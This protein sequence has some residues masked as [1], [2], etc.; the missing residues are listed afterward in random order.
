M[1]LNESPTQAISPPEHYI[2]STERA[3][4]AVIAG[5]AYNVLDLTN[6]VIVELLLDGISVSLA[7]ADTYEPVL[8]ATGIGDGCHG[9]SFV[10]TPGMLIGGRVAQVVIANRR[11]VIAPPILLGDGPSRN[12]T[13]ALAPG[14]AEWLGGLHL[15]GWLRPG[16]DRERL[17]VRVRIDGEVV[18]LSH[19]DRWRHLAGSGVLRL[20]P[21]FSLH[22]PERF[23]DGHTKQ[24]HITDGRGI[25]LRGSPLHLV[26]LPDP[27]E[28]LAAGAYG[29]EAG[30]TAVRA[31]LFDTLLPASRTLA[32]MS[33]WLETYPNP[34]ADALECCLALIVLGASPE[35]IQLVRQEL[36]HDKLKALVIGSISSKDRFG[37]CPE[38][39]TDFL[40]SEAG[41]CSSVLVVQAGTR[42]RPGSATRLAA[43][44]KADESA[45]L[46]YG[47]VAIV[48]RGD[49]VHHTSLSESPIG[50]PCFDYERW[51][52]QGYG[53][54]FMALP[55]ERALLALRGGAD[56]VFRLANAQFDDLE[57]ERGRIVHLPGIAATLPPL[58]LQA[59][60]QHLVAATNQHLAA[61]GHSAQVHPSS[62]CC[63]PSVR[64]S[65]R[66][67][68]CS[69]TVIIPTQDRADLLEDCV[70]SIRPAIER[71]NARLLIVDNCSVNPKTRSLLHTLSQQGARVLTEPG[72]FNYARLV[73][74]GVEASSSDF[75]CLLHDDVVATDPDWLSELAGRLAEPM[76]VA[77]A[78]LLH[79]PTGVVQHA[80]ITLG[81][82]FAVGHAFRDRLT[83]DAGYG[84]LLRVA[85]EP[86]A[87]A[88]ACLLV[89]R[90]SFQFVGGMD[91][92]MFPMHF[93]DVDLCL[94]LRS[95]GG[96]TILSPHAQ[97]VHKGSGY[98][99]R[100][101]RPEHQGLAQRE[102]AALRARWGAVLCEDPAYSPLLALSALPYSALACPPRE[103]RRR[104]WGF[105]PPAPLPKGF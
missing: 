14:Q 55:I 97:L 64:V 103:R 99:D 50:F 12:A 35:D 68:N 88:S 79:W 92:M 71:M 32:D 43:T 16:D 6:P 77:A 4:T 104:R 85:S 78:P 30:V 66:Q 70:A 24:V 105:V 58:N 46:V 2:L 9:F 75:V 19:P 60:T 7:R 93:S 48:S 72:F 10:L 22:L 100:A 61:R 5:Y 54:L 95:A 8:A 102:L 83:E 84:D 53:A 80:G 82:G 57:G 39:V 37:F 73:N 1:T 51:L 86:S 65:R 25:A 98:R 3:G 96:A 52:E 11:D 31:R 38:D 47:D 62:G 87:L 18:A 40:T 17:Q 76:T 42:I 27:L 94:R 69:V 101:L 74:R 23:A 56:N 33:I 81:P 41:A 15:S 28:R 59:A 49:G 13:A 26:A 34:P 89:R 90:E 44:L 29:C 45:S 63:L 36:R 91:E 67:P 20:V 21:A